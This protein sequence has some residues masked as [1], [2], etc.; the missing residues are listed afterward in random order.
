MG[1]ELAS[2]NILAVWVKR[3]GKE[4]ADWLIAVR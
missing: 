4:E 1:P 3:P 2:E